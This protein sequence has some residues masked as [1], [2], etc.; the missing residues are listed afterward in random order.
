M[1]IVLMI[2]CLGLILSACHPTPPVAGP[3]NTT[4]ALAQNQTSNGLAMN[5]TVTGP[6][7]NLRV[8]PLV[9]GSASCGIN[10]FIISGQT[11]NV[12]LTAI[13]GQNGD[14]NGARVRMG[15][16][17]G[18]ST[19]NGSIA[20]DGPGCSSTVGPSLSIMT[21]FSGTHVALIDKGRSPMCVFQSKLTLPTFNQTIQAGLPLD[22]SGM[23]KKA[24]QG[25][26]E[27]RIDF[28]LAKA[29]NGLLNA[30]ADLGGTF[31]ADSGR[32]HNDWQPFTE[33]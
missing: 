16:T 14:D 7:P 15:V 17:I 8:D 25:A 29:V 10:S 3:T 23:T 31:A 9:A 11:V 1:K 32:C 24:V 28:E 19:H 30:S 20:K 6:I 21:T 5:C 27:K 2:F 26:I 4:C 13:Y 33:N 22:I 18:N 12:P